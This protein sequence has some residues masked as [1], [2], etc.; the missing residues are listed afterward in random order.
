MPC[1][2]RIAPTAVLA[3]AAALAIAVLAPHMSAHAA[4]AQEDG[5][6]ASEPGPDASS[7]ESDESPDGNVVRPDTRRDKAQ[8]EVIYDLDRLPEPVRRMRRLIV[9]AARSGDI[10]RLRP[11][12]GTGEHPTQLS[13]GV[14]ETDPIQFLREVSGDDQGHEILAILL[15]VMEAGFVRLN[16]GTERELYVWPYFFALPLEGLTPEQRVELFTLVTAGDYAD[17]KTFGAYI[18]YRAAITPE[19]HW[20]FFVAGD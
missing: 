2:A 12:L 16:P 5:T 11:L 7:T 13:L 17:M 15:E 18:F 20:L 19:G 10:E 8:P 6:T 1:I 9:E 3:L 14:V 4:R